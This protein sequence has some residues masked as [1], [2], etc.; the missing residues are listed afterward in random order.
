MEEAHITIK[1]KENEKTQIYN[2]SKKNIIYDLYS[3]FEKVKNKQKEVKKAK[4]EII[5]SKINNKDKNLDENDKEIIVNGKNNITKNTLIN[6]NNSTNIS[7]EKP[8]IN[9]DISSN[10]SSENKN[11]KNN[12]NNQNNIIINNIN[13]NNNLKNS[14]NNNNCNIYNNISNNS[15]ISNTNSNI[16]N[17]NNINTNNNNNYNNNYYNNNFNNNFNNNQ[18]SNNN[19]QISSN[20]NQINNY[21]N[22]INNI[23]INIPYFFPLVGLRNVGSTCFMNATLQCLLHISELSLYFLNE[24]PNDCQTLK[25]KNKNSHA[26]GDISKAYYDIVKGVDLIN[27]E[28]SKTNNN[29]MNNFY[30][31]AYSPNEFKRILGNYNSQFSINEANDS[32]DLILYLLQTF[33]E[34]LNYFGDVPFPTNI[35]QPRQVDRVNYFN[36][37]ISTY[38]FQNFSI[39]SKLFFGTYETMTQ[40]SLCKNIFY[41]Y[42]KFEFISFGT[43]KY[44]NDIF[45]I[46]SGFNDYQEMQYLTGNN[47]YYCQI[48]Q[49]LC[50]ATICCKIIQPP[51][52][53]VINIDYGK[54]KKYEVRQLVFDEM[55]DI[56]NYINFNFGKRIIYRLLGVCTHLGFSGA[57]GHYIAYCRNNQTGK[58]YN[59]NDSSCRECSMH[60]IYGGSPY[61]LLY[62][63]I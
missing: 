27:S 57:S 63:Q 33:H 51:N 3:I 8:L 5:E 20:N 38:N 26:K 21:N 46:Y 42:Q 25:F 48:C 18:I 17:L 19:N 58:W 59:F 34:E 6:S 12:I 31:Y 14:Q 53:L 36:Y 52:K 30:S 15:D 1:I 2:I 10:A 45:N 11:T 44:R 22:Q 24:F 50:D 35:I 37:F 55:I 28:K 62:E 60:E 4:T 13:E 41:N 29:F 40:C 54:N 16:Q 32:K 49:K 39:V 47:Q 9:N 7:S 23:N 43:Q 56:T 61:L